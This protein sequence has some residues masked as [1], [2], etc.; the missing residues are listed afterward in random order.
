MNKILI[1][2]GAGKVGGA[3]ARKLVE[4]RNY[5]EWMKTINTNVIGFTNLLYSVLPS[6]IKNILSM[7]IIGPSLSKA[8]MYMSRSPSLSISPELAVW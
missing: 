1:T 2:G 7:S 3:L 6:L 4:N 8:D 5:E